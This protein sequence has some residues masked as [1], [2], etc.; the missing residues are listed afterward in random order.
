MSK[1]DCYSKLIDKVIH[2]KLIN[3]RIFKFFTN[4]IYRFKI[5]RAYDASLT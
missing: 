4:I 5:N 2:T 3:L 1:G